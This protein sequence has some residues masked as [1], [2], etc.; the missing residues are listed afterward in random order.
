MSAWWQWRSTGWRSAGRGIALGVCVAGV[1]WGQTV[2][3]K[4]VTID[5]EK[6]RV[7]FP[8][9]INMAEG[10]LEYLLVNVMGKTHESLLS[11]KIEPVDLQVAMLLVGFKPAEKSDTQPPAQINIEYLR[12]APELKGARV[13]ISLEWKDEKGPHAMKAEDMIWNTKEN[14]AAP[15]GVWTYNGSEVY[16]GKF[17][18]QVDGS[19]VALVRDSAAM[20]NNPR[21]GNDNDQIWEVNGRV[22]PKVGTAVEVIIEKEPD[23]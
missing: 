12:G 15:E 18:A 16:M 19:V 1:A 3:L 2:E 21:P 14:R 8:A 11:T 23:K 5:K 17:L 13:G 10:N 9:A 22:T 20:I 6:G 4:G 7:S